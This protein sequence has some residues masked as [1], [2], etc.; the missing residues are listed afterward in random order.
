[1]SGKASSASEGMTDG[2]LCS[3]LVG[4]STGGNTIYKETSVT[5]GGRMT[6]VCVCVCVCVGVYDHR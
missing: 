6:G 2:T 1:M 4:T 3:T 5:I